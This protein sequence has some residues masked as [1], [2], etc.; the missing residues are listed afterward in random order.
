MA[1]DLPNHAVAI[2]GIGCR[3]PGGA[4]TP[5]RFWRLLRDGVDAITEIPAD[6]FDLDDVYDPD[7]AAPGKIYARWG[8]FVENVDRFDAE[9]FGIAPREAKRM[10]PQ[11]RLLL[12]VIW[13][14]LEDG[15]QV[16][17]RLAG[18]D[19]GV[20][21][22]ISTHDYAD[23]HLTPDRWPMLD[24]HVSIGN[25]MC[26]APNR[27]SYLLD[28]RGPSLAVDTACS[29]SLTAL[30]L[31]KR[32]LA[33]GESDQAIVAGVNLILSPGLTIGFCKA[34]MISPN[35][36]CQAFG[37]GA[38]G[39][40]RSEGAGAVVLK[41]LARALADGDPIYAVL[42]G[43]AT[44]QDGRTTG[45]SLPS[46]DAQ[47]RLM[48]RA[49][50]D[51]AV[52]ASEVQVVEAH[53]TGTAA[54]D[55]VEA[56]ALGR[57]Y[58][59][60]RAIGE[61]L[62]VGS[63]KS[64][65]GHLEAGA[66]IVG[67][68]KTALMLHHRQVPASL[69]AERPNPEIPF[70]DYGFRVPT[71][72]TPWPDTAGP[73]LAGVGSSGFGGAN[74]HAV[75]QEPPR[76]PA[77]DDPAAHRTVVL[78]LSARS[79]AALRATAERY[80]DL[81]R[82]EDAPRLADVCATA[83]LRRSHHEHRLAVVG[84]TTEE[85][86]GHLDAYLAG[87]PSA[88]V[89]TG[90]APKS[91][92]PKLAFV[93]SGMGPQWWAMGRELLETEPVFRGALE[94]CDRAL[95]PT[96]GWSLI[97]ELTA[98]ETAS[99][100]SETRVVQV[101]NCALQ[102]ALA[103]L[104]KHWGVVPDAVVGHSAG[105]MAAAHVA[106]ALDLGDAL[107]VAYHRGR[108]LHRS[109]GTGTMLAAGVSVDEAE[110]LLDGYADRV[111]IAAINAPEAVTLS[112][113]REALEAIAGVLEARERFHRFL[114]TDVPYHAPQVEA[115]RE[116]LLAA[117]VD[118]APRPPAV[119]MASE[120]TGTW[121]AEEALDGDYWWRNIRQ[122]VRFAACV[123]TLL[124]E[125][126]D[127][128]CEIGPHPVLASYLATCAAARDT[129]VTL[130]ASL[131]RF[132]DERRTM[133]QAL[134]KLHARGVRVDWEQVLPVG[135]PV[136]LPTYPWQRE[137]HW[138]D[139]APTDTGTLSGTDTHHPLLGRRLRTARPSW[140]A[141]LSDPRAE[142]LSEH[143]VQGSA[144]FPGAGY[145][146]LAL[147]AAHHEGR[148]AP[149]TLERIE[150]RKLLF[151]GEGRERTLHVLQSLDGTIEIHAAPRAEAQPTWTLHAT[152][153]LRDVPPPDAATVPD[154]AALRVRCAEPVDV[155]EYYALLESYGFRYGPAFR[156]LREA[157]AGDR[158]ALARVEFPTGG[159]RPTDA[160]EIHPAL[161]D[162]AFQLLASAGGLAARTDEGSGGPLFPRS[163]RRVTLH[164][165]PGAGFWVHARVD[166]S[167]DAVILGDVT[168]FDDAGT[169]CV[170]CEGLHL[171][172]LEEARSSAGEREGI[173]DWL[174]ELR[175]HQASLHVPPD[176]RSA[177]AGAVVRSPVD[178]A[179]RLA[180]RPHPEADPELATYHAQ[181][182]PA[183]DRIA[184]GY[185]R[186]ALAELRGD[187]TDAEGAAA[188]PVTS[189][190]VRLVRELM[191]KD[192]ARPPDGAPTVADLRIELAALADRWPAFEA[193]TRLLRAGGDAL[194]DVLRGDVDAREILLTEAGL[195]LLGRMYHL[196][197]SC[198][199]YHALLA[200]AV[201]AARAGGAVGDDARPLRVL[202]V[203]AGTGAA[204]ATLLE[205]LPV[206][207]EY[208][209]T[210][211]SP[212]FV[213]EAIVRF[214]NRTGFRAATLDVERDPRDQGF[215]LGS[216]DLIVAANVLH[217]TAD[218]R[219]TLGHLR[220]LLAPGGDLALLELALRGTW[221][222]LVFGLLDGWWRF[223]DTDL[224][225]DY[226]L[227]DGD[228]W[229]AVL[230]EVG[231]EQVTTV[232]GDPDGALQTVVVA[233]APAERVADEARS[234]SRAHERRRWV[235][236]ADTGGVGRRLAATLRARG[237]EVVEVA[238][239]QAYRRTDV[240]AFDLALDDGLGYETLLS[241]LDADGRPP[242][243]VVHLWSL[244]TELPATATSDDVMDAQRT[245]TES[246]FMLARALELGGHAP[247][248]L[249]LV[250]AGAQATPGLEAAI[251]AATHVER[252]SLW[253]LGRVLMNAHVAGRTRLVDLS[254]SPTDAEI[255]ALADELH[256]D[257][258]EEE[259]ALHAGGRFVR[260]LERTPLEP[261]PR[262]GATLHDVSPDAAAFRLTN[263]TPGVLDGLVLREVTLPEPGLGEVAIRVRASGLNFRDVLLALGT[264]PSP[265]GG[266]DDPSDAL[267]GE[268]SGTVIACGEGVTAFRPGDEVIALA[269]GTF[270]S[271]VV[272]NALR[273]ALKPARLSFTEAASVANAF[274]TAEYALDHVARLQPGERVLIHAA[275]GA[276]GWAAIQVARRAGAEV[277]ATAGSP[278]KRDHLR[279]QGVR[280]VMD[281]RSL[282]FIDGVREATD[283]EG[284]DVVLNSLTGEAMRASLAL[285]RPYGRFVELGKRDVFEDTHIG[286]A[287]FAR[288]LTYTAV[289]LIQ[290][291]RDRP[292]PA[293][294][295]LR[296]VLERIEDGTYTPPPCTVFDLGEAEAAF[297][298]MA[299][300]RHVGKVVVTVDEPAYAV[301][302]A[303][304][305]TACRPDG[306]YLVTG[307]LGGFGLAVAGWLARQGARHLVLMS[308]TGEPKGE[309]E[310][311]EALKGAGV[312]VVQARGDVANAADVA[313]VVEAIAD[314][315][316]PLAGVV[317]AA[318]V[319]DDDVVARLDPAR[320][321]AVLAPKVAGAWNLHRATVDTDLD[322]FV[323]FSSAASVLGQP[324]QANYAAANAFLDALA[325]HLQALGRSALT[326]G[327]GAIA[328]VGYVARHP[329]VAQYVARGGLDSFT[330]D[331][332]CDALGDLL[333]R[334]R[335]H[336]LAARVDWRRLMETSPVLAASPR[337]ER[338]GPAPVAPGRA[339]TDARDAAPLVKLRAV[340][341]EERMTAVRR[342][343]VERVARV[344]GGDPDRVD[345]ARSLTEI[346]FDSLMAVE[347]T[348]LV[349][350]D[351]DV[352]LR[353]VQ[354]LEGGSAS[355]LAAT[356]HERLF[357]AE[358]G[359]A[360]APT[361][362]PTHPDHVEPPDT[363]AHMLSFEQRRLWFLHRLDPTD[364]AYH[365]PIAVR[366]S[367][368]LDVDALRGALH[369]VVAR[370]DVLRATFVEREDEVVQV[371]GTPGDVD[372][373][374]VVLEG[375]AGVDREAA[376]QR[377]A[378][379]AIRAPFDLEGGGP[380]RARLFRLAAAEHVLML[381]VHHIACDAW[382]MNW[383]AREIA[384]RYDELV[385]GRPS[386]SKP[387][388][389][390][391]ADYVARERER[392]DEA[393][394]DRQVGYW[395]RRLA[396]ANPHLGLPEYRARATG[397][398]RR[399]AHV[400]FALSEATTAALE[401]FGRAEGVTLF[402]TLLA[403][404]QA[405][406]HRLSGEDDVSI[407]TPVATRG[408]REEAVV[409][410]F[411][412]TVVLRS[413][414]RDD[415]TFRA[416][417]Q[418]TRRSTLEALEH[419]DAPFERVVEV[420]RSD[421]GPAMRSPFEAMLV[422]HQARLPELRVAGLDLEPVEVESG[423]AVADLVLLLDAGERLHGVLE[424]DAERFDADTVRR[425][426]D[427][428][429]ATLDAV[430]AEPD[431]PLSSLPPVTPTER[432]EVLQTWN[433]TDVDLGPP[434]C[435]HALVAAQAM[436]TPL[437]VAVVCGG[438][439][440]TYAEL[441][442]R[443]EHLAGRLRGLG[444]GP[445]DVVAVALPRSTATV[446]AALG[447]LQAGGA[448]LPLDLTQPDARLRDLCAD[449]RPMV[450]VAGATPPSWATDL[451]ASV[452]HVDPMG[453][454][455]DAD[456][457]AD[458]ARIELPAHV[459][460]D[461]TAYVLY[462]SGSTG[463]PKGVVVPH[464][465]IAH[466]I[467]WRQRTYPLTR[468]DAVLFHT[469]VGFDP[470]IW[471]TFGP[472][473]AGAR[474]V[475]PT[476]EEDADLAARVALIA[477]ERVSAL[478]A[479]PSVL[480]AL[481]E[482]P[483]VASWH[484]MKH[485]FC[486][487]E[488]L[489][490]SLARRFFERLPNAGLHHLYGPTETTIDATSWDVELERADV[491][492]PIGRPIAGARVY[493]LDPE[494]RPVPVG[495]PGELYV[496]GA[497]VAHGY[498][499][500][501]DLTAARFLED[502][503]ASEVGER[504]FRTGDRGRWRADGALAFLGR[505][506]RQVKVRGVRVEPAEAE[507]A[508]LS[509][510]HVREAAVVAVAGRAPE[511]GLT[512]FVV[513]TAPTDV[514]ELQRFVADRVPATS[515]P[516]TVALCA[517]LPR[518]ASGKVDLERLARAP[519]AVATSQGVADAKR[520][521][522]PPRD[523]V[524]LRLVRLWEEFFPEREVGVTDDFFDLGGHSLMALRL[525]ARVER[526]FVVHVPV[527]ALMRESTVERLAAL[528]RADA[529]P[530]SALVPMRTGGDG[531]PLFCVHPAGGDVACYHELAR[532]LDDR[533]VFGLQAHGL[534]RGETPDDRIEVMADRCI[535]AV[536][537]VDY[538]GPIHL[539]GWSLGG[540]VA[541]E[542]AR[543]LAVR[544]RDVGL[545]AL[546]DTSHPTLNGDASPDEVAALL[547]EAARVLGVPA[548]A[549]VA[550][551]GTADLATTDEVIDRL[552]AH[553]PRGAAVPDLDDGAWRRRIDAFASHLE[554]VRR[555]EP[556][557][558][559]GRLHVFD[560]QTPTVGVARRRPPW[561]Y[562]AAGG[563]VRETLPGGHYDLLRRPHVAVLAT[564]L[565]AALASQDPARA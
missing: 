90:R 68:I 285:L 244:D 17:E 339:P 456:P 323:L 141:D 438:E 51:A 356:V 111:A 424:Y 416:F 193:E 53:G 139:P 31:A 302:R 272:V 181:V 143:V 471:E 180:P 160:F 382:S 188:V 210:D 284:V 413:R 269:W 240:H 505:L 288:N 496:A 485:V 434:A 225:P 327:W 153:S 428:L 516:A 231:F 61:P 376:F 133:L 554:A 75:L 97:D 328:D 34:S 242:D 99:R 491:D 236:F 107:R 74:A 295:M 440:T 395:R 155:G 135:E 57:V 502:P 186:A 73:A 267:G 108:L 551:A 333:R 332:A 106:G 154:L 5:E 464:R 209:F 345:P 216:F 384:T 478:Q 149:R 241:A 449:A 497:G 536:H 110:T 378:T 76:R 37:A 490:S 48:R 565:R 500:R 334:D 66:G 234:E 220:D 394:I 206:G 314:R 465:A 546:L 481:L 297:R 144:I 94:A 81:L 298:L 300:A 10:D 125:G 477:R 165:P 341:P 311:L 120:V 532:A 346:G 442:R 18:T 484:R 145:V 548:D 340:P 355:D 67:L 49:L 254:T 450:L 361:T 123:D 483:G 277:F 157:W 498:L 60:A 291:T 433:D 344:L 199:P 426:L 466:Q 534:A 205:A 25:A 26:A 489:T 69:H 203:G 414:L 523:D 87:E 331:Q 342:Y 52:D 386:S 407:A 98:D 274:V 114:P 167:D 370:H 294:R 445:D 408:P 207:T 283:G 127:A 474:I 525:I 282:D 401:R 377:Q 343:L 463:A 21:V 185:T 271:R 470:S 553:G 383:L 347:L 550:A 32:S 162:A 538:D 537:E 469:P 89:A 119:P 403:A 79:E 526:A 191:R 439:R 116:D 521:P 419:R 479:V 184:A 448:Y 38:N 104:W 215:E 544:G 239:A 529:G 451:D 308:R 547:V 392:L 273:V 250:T 305:R 77:R 221:Y 468:A 494:R 197:P 555:Y 22:G 482:Q 499:R 96:S 318:M 336:V 431:R 204:T 255:A 2:V 261:P 166:R 358:D 217:A 319:L 229:R 338:V 150:F 303:D 263:A 198:A 379:A 118:L 337:F 512:A 15:G 42:R 488:R 92:A 30:H 179:T 293:E 429:A 257:D 71:T 363:E 232:G 389:A 195:D 425:L 211:V 252:A 492:A 513:T 326:V 41:P 259:V 360:P 63:S 194:A 430:V 359:V 367:G 156:G 509:H 560:A 459:T 173:D 59:R 103:A 545:L 517:A 316:P 387:P 83:A 353:V 495:V 70:G 335:S 182:A 147:A 222:D 306:T 253:G 290:L 95:T 281:S 101:V 427:Q 137:R 65:L 187:A 124:D 462:T 539:V 146:D 506:D 280:I 374:I 411:M 304:A 524:E 226:P 113:E 279:S 168:I 45:I 161:L 126:V 4:D 176:A 455:I 54:G 39:Y 391:Y 152:A 237:D 507:A 29:S 235:F 264:L 530:T 88:A 131:R 397:S 151:L 422:L 136:R 518:A 325:A 260:R 177:G 315:G 72:L 322:F 373:A 230:H 223:R 457:A 245:G 265:V 109:S 390:R 522:V 7:P 542:V 102:I 351:L 541:V 510:P 508:L 557:P 406:L 43:S 349:H 452:V 130:T 364:P 117:L 472:L 201:G 531:A 454:L 435:L 520:N 400:P 121:V 228:G 399:G 243:G 13:E 40:V 480:D 324:M 275:T 559:A 11:H 309:D 62:L 519:E 402:T 514:R 84:T 365:I 528:L 286:L 486:G 375:A 148:D 446:A 289:D 317:H 549:L 515:V 372:L 175:W 330:P 501:P 28:L 142:F 91:R 112:G 238:R 432:H 132:D 64:N 487:G 47:E 178:V 461:H 183:L 321:R 371:F 409:G 82:S 36:R 503:F 453:E 420:L 224:R 362:E 218:L 138:F 270:G 3:L 564:R 134:A 368:E 248:A 8:G 475:V 14:A 213:H 78:P 122:P 171:E 9:F 393:L 410:C 561:Q 493:V 115:H 208:V 24:Q 80:R 172:V 535:D 352:Q 320:F 405:V 50:Q 249:W 415:P 511:D 128:F 227:L 562:L 329:E 129:R 543:R 418:R 404:F 258:L 174:Y 354:L 256:A 55:P 159:G 348:T 200:D 350:T 396:D 292:E 44:N 436:R 164:R 140:H 196:S 105:E 16:P 251:G 192:D 169:L 158:E 388:T 301:A 299:Q 6:R 398:A 100:I 20:F 307:G 170:T 417:L 287:P 563:V 476:P 202:E 268:C 85:I 262:A 421:H 447:V 527:A 423:A 35:G 86:V 1:V 219:T 556:G 310:A 443:A 276:V 458:G 247:S 437:A 540:F 357:A 214:A 412:N 189:K 56:E 380:L 93:F 12:E 444:V 33:T 366:L 58:G 460:P 46:A 533:P 552:R 473:A 27:V 266:T 312:R 467:R 296:A 369:D 246:A 23:L 313:R 163:L 278:E 233:Q 381:V 19:T 504:M 385:A 441:T 558:I 212:R 190:Y